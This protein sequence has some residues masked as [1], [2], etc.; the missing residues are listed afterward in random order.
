MKA[1]IATYATVIILAGLIIWGG[2][3]FV[4]RWNYVLGYEAMVKET[5]REMVR[6]EALK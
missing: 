3:I 5:I 1:M 6:E 2:W 4:R